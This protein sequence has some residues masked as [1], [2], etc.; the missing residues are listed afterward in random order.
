MRTLCVLTFET[1]MGNRYLYDGNT[2]TVLPVDDILMDC[3]LAYEKEDTNQIQSELYSKYENHRKV[4]IAMKFVEDFIR[5][6]GA[7]YRDEEYRRRER[8]WLNNFDGLSVQ[9]AL[10]QAG[11]MEQI[12]INVTEDC[13]LRC[14]YCFLSETY[15]HTRN[16]TNNVMQDDVAIQALNY[17]FRKM[18][19]ISEYNPGKMCAI[20]FYGGEPLLNFKL[21]KKCVEYAKKNCPISVIFNLTTNGILLKDEIADY[22]VEQGVFIS[23]SFDGTRENHD[24][25]RTGTQCLG[26]YDIIYKNLK[27]FMQK[28]PDYIRINILCVFDY[29]TNLMQNEAY[30]KQENLPRISFINQVLSENTEYYN[31]FTEQD[32]EAFQ[33]SYI[34]MLNQFYENKKT[35]KLPDSYA[36]M[37]FETSL[38]LVLCR[39]RM[40]DKRLPILPFTNTCLPGTKISV[41][42]DGTFDMCEKIDYRFPIGN[43]YDGL[44]YEGIAEIIRT[45]NNA[46]TG[47]CHACP[48]SKICTTCFAHCSSDDGFK[49]ANCEEQISIFIFQLSLVYS[50]Y[51]ENSHV[52]DYFE[53]KVEWT[54][55]L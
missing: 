33:N 18:K 36:D 13:N 25:N 42:T 2:A 52:F 53:N 55:H 12:V 44:N 45:Y 17:F 1:R 40:E 50:L 27:S 34:Q 3:I 28:Y 26:S 19:K 48:I 14:K 7:F 22:L 37:L 15:D 20:T 35:G 24:R 54:F 9:A 43:V 39:G 6:K 47:K 51:E 21:I 11:F 5:Y 30:F 4:D 8:K 29:K 38:A 31:Q 16:R 49:T 23:V 46:V 41:R 10:E 32:M